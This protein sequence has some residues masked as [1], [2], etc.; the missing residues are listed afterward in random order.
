MKR[1]L[2]CHRLAGIASAKHGGV[3][4]DTSILCSTPSDLNGSVERGEESSEAAYRSVSLAEPVS[5]SQCFL[6]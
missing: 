2:E 1:G 4:G 6:L 3:S 5:S